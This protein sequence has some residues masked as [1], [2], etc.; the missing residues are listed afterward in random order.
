MPKPAT[1]QQRRDPRIARWIARK[2]ATQSLRAPSLIITVW[3]DAVLPHGGAALLP[4]LIEILAAFGLNERH[5]R[6]SMYRLVQQGWLTATPVGRRSLYALTADGARRFAEARRR[7]YA[8]P[9]VEWDESW[10]LV[11]ADGLSGAERRQLATELHWAGL[12]DFGN[13][14]FARP[15]QPESPVRRIVE[16]RGVAGDV[17]IV[18][19]NDLPDAGGRTLASMVDKAWDLDGVATQY[20]R[21]LQRFGTVIERFREQDDARHDPLQCFVVRTLLIH[22]YRRALL[23]D[24]RLPAS[25]LPLDWPGAAAYALCRDFYRLT[26][27]AAERYLAATLESEDGPLPPADAAFYQRF[28]GLPTD[29]RIEV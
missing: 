29:A 21:V 3:G 13:G 17:A 12:G 28:E 2:L 14:V 9:A 23:R 20:R 7:I 11:I 27:R 25:L 16:A 22:A 8:M 6:T 4:G 19:A 26:H 1:P 15:M 10:E 5:V 18:R 24:P